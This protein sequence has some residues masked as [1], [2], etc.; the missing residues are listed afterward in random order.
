MP[1]VCA[2]ASDTDKVDAIEPNTA[3][4]PI[5][6]SAFLRDIASGLVISFMSTSNLAIKVAHPA[7]LHPGVCGDACGAAS[8]PAVCVTKCLG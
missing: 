4:N 8:M 7:H 1:T 6:A 5:M 2:S 3:P